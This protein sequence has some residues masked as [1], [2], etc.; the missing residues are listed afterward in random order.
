MIDRIL[1]GLREAI[2]GR[3]TVKTRIGYYS[4]AEF[5]DLLAVFAQ[6]DID[7]LT[8]HGRTVKER[9]ATPVHPDCIAE[10]VAVMKCPVIANGNVVDVRTAQALHEQTGAAGLMIG[11]GAIR[12]PWIFEQIRAAWRGEQPTALTRR[13]LLGYVHR[14]FDET[15]SLQRNFD[16]QK[17][18]TRLKKY[19]KYIAQQAGGDFDREICRA[20]TPADF[21]AICR[22]HLENDDEL[23]VLPPAD[24]RLF[25]GFGD[26]LGRVPS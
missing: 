5:A 6:H 8:I 19:L 24:S 14:L 25:C 3:F 16:A 20:R 9:Y 4:E 13:D 18:I 26:L 23:E 11:R 7:A 17:H 15:A 2:D 12:S 1:G 22:A 21:F 10:A